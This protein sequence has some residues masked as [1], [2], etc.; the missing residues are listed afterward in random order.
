M[1]SIIIP[2][3]KAAATIRRC[4]KSVLNQTYND[5]EL[6]LVDDGSPDESGLICDEFSMIDS[7]VCVIHQKNAGPSVARNNGIFYAKGDIITFIDSDDWIE[8]DYLEMMKKKWDCIRCDLVVSGIERNFPSKTEYLVTDDRQ[9]TIETSNADFFHELVLS[10]LIY[11]PCNKFYSR[12]VIQ[13]NNIVFPSNLDYGED[14]LFNYKYLKHT[15]TVATTAYCGYHYVMGNEESLSSKKRENLFEL[16]LSQW[17]ELRSVYTQ[18]DVLTKK[19]LEDLLIDLYW[20]IN[21]HAFESAAKGIIS[22]LKNVRFI[23]STP[24]IDEFKKIEYLIKQNRVIKCCILHRQSLLL[25]MIKAF[26]KR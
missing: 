6:I 16:E 26:K 15:N 21:D 9:F 11:G 25:C 5:Y 1:I 19:V 4:V 23:L 2:V 20:I 17:R 22:G 3:Y 7:R 14:R 8:Q 10:K 18:K 13:D 24:E 12:K